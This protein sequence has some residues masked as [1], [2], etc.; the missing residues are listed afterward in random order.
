[1]SWVLLIYFYSYHGPAITMSQRFPNK[2][3]C[4]RAANWYATNNNDMPTGMNVK[5]ACFE[6]FKK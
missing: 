6:D 2:S 3:S 5:T 1:M 4:E